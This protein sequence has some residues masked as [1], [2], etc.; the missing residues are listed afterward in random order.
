MSLS[1]LCLPCYQ[2]AIKINPIA[3]FFKSSFELHMKHPPVLKIFE[4]KSSALHSK[5]L[6]I[7]SSIH[8]TVLL[9]SI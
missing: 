7:N 4:K 6:T 9:V 3:I 5:L 2:S 1:C 8:I